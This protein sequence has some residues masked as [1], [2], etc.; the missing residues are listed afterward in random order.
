MEQINNIEEIKFKVCKTCNEPK[1]LSR[2][3]PS[4]RECKTCNN[5]KDA[6]NKLKRNIKFYDSH[7][8]ELQKVNLLNYYKRKYD[9]IN[10]SMHEVN[11][12]RIQV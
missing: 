2:Y 10:I 6:T 4:C 9:D 11:L 8:E 7:K 3:R 1:E 5:K 12:Y